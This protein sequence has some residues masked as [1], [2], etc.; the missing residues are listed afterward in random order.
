MPSPFPGMDPYLENP[1]LWPDVHHELISVIRAS[2]NQQLGPKYLVRIEE[3]LYLCDETDPGRSVIIPDLRVAR[4][5][6]SGRQPHQPSSTAG[7]AIVEPLVMVTL[8]D[9]DIHEPRLEILDS[10]SRRVV[11]VLEI[12]SPTNKVAGSRGRESYR[13]K[14]VEILHSPTHLIEI[15][16]LRAGVSFVTRTRLP[17]CDYFVHVSRRQSRPKGQVWP[18][19][20]QKPLPVIAIPLQPKDADA[21]LD[22]Q[23]ALDTAYDRARYGALIDYRADPVPPLQDETAVWAAE[24]LTN[25]GL[26]KVQPRRRGSK[27]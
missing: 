14:R 12:L 20:L 9:D 3:R 25:K 16:L 23:E 18:I 6:G 4:P 2:L 11:T 15:D 10:E 7:L 1:A 27:R 17:P 19:P 8:L 26:R 13:E 22:L 24:L 21:K 5:S